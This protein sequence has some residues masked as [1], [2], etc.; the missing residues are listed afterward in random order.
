MEEKVK[1]EEV[2]NGK[3]FHI[4]DLFQ[5]LHVKD[6]F[7]GR[8]I[9]NDILI[10]QWKRILVIVILLFVYISNRYT[11]QQKIAQIGELQKQLVDIRYEALTLSS[12]LMGSSRQS[13]VEKLIESKGLDLHKSKQPPFKLV[14]N[15]HGNR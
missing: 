15:K 1:T 13:Q 10:R 8:F 12:K 4:G 7:L 2:K 3:G 6:I 11:C 9:S 14:K 5:G